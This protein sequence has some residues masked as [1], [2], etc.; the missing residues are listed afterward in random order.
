MEER[1]LYVR[2]MQE[3]RKHVRIEIDQMVEMRFGH[4][5]FLRAEGVDVSEKGLLCVSADPVDP[6]TRIFVMFRLP[7]RHE[8]YE[9][10]CEGIVIR[11]E[12]HD[13]N[14]AVAVQFTN[15]KA[16]DQKAIEA[17][18]RNHVAEQEKRK[19]EGKKKDSGG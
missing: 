8:D 16:A 4:E 17:F 6:Q 5:H 9:V 14:Y 18:T 7:I 13:E 10:Q 1:R 19:A 12:K 3:R 2:D 15:L 11:S